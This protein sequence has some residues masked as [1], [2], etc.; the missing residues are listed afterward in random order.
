MIKL[1]FSAFAALVASLLALAGCG[2]SLQPPAAQIGDASLTVTVRLA[3]PGRMPPGAEVEIMLSDISGVVP[4]P[5]AGDT[6]RISEGD[7]SIR[8]SVPADAQKI[9]RCRKKGTC[10]VFV[11]IKKSGSVLYRNASPVAYVHSQRNITVHVKS[12]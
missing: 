9:N 5:L 4:A 12:G 3:S 8:V 6:I 7:R 10:G 11:R 1:R 2:G